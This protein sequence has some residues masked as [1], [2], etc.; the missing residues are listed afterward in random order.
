M[1]K[2]VGRNFLRGGLQGRAPSH[3][4]IS[5]GGAAQPRFW[6][7]SMVKMKEF[8]GQGGAMAPS[9]LCLPTPLVVW[10]YFRKKIT[11][12]HPGGQRCWSSN[13]RSFDR[14]SSLRGRDWRDWSLRCTIRPHAPPAGTQPRFLK[15]LE[16]MKH[17]ANG[18]VCTMYCMVRN[19]NTCI[20]LNL[21]LTYTHMHANGHTC[22]IVH[23][24]VNLYINRY[25]FHPHHQS[26]IC[27]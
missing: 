20:S 6:V 19:R 18:H 2:G 10:Y 13:L 26:C 9:C 12:R 8:S 1:R 4:L 14:W 21:K 15:S 23:A 27:E 7:A 3:F 22:T 11:F 16:I 24:F 17:N 25:S 5:R